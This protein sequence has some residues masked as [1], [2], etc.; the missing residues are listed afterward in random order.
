LCI[1]HDVT[2]EASE[3]VPRRLGYALTGEIACERQLGPADT[4]TD[5]VWEVTR[6][7]WPGYASLA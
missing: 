1:A 4:G 7:A 5:R 6:A 3:G 2:N